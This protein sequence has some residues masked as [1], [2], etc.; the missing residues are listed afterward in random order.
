[1]DVGSGRRE[2][3]W[4][5]GR[6]RDRRESSG[7]RVGSSESFGMLGSR[8]RESFWTTLG[9]VVENLS[10]QRCVGSS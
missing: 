8:R 3:F 10:G 4:T 6:R 1:M 9:R 2:S 7:C 5:S